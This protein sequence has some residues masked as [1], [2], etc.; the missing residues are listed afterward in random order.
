MIGSVGGIVL[1]VTDLERSIGFYEG[2]L[3][4][5][6]GFADDVSRAYTLGQHDFVLLA[7]PGA[8]SMLGDDA[9]QPAR[10]G[11]R[12]VMLCVHT[13]DVDAAHAALVAKGVTI[14]RPPKSQDWGR[15]TTHF[16]DPDGNVWEFYQFLE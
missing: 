2:V 5:K 12:R 1:F 3:G 8:V 14:I 9:V 16:A 15:R 11:V 7:L 6:P 13:P 10:D 4:L